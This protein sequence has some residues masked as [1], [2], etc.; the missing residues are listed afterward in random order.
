MLRSLSDNLGAQLTNLAA[1]GAGIGMNIAATFHQEADHS[2]HRQGTSIEGPAVVGLPSEQHNAPHPPHLEP[3][4]TIETDQQRTQVTTT[5]VESPPE[6][7]MQTTV[8]GVDEIVRP[9]PPPPPP[10][11]D[12]PSEGKK[13]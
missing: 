6:P 8:Y 7:R 12:N 13:K 11:N 4:E 3:I 2:Q 10:A 1:A 9:P 5:L